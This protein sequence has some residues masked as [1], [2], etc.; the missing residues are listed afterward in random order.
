[1]APGT[2]NLGCMGW[3]NATS[4]S[5]HFAGTVYDSGVSHAAVS[6][7]NGD[8]VLLDEGFALGINN[9]GQAVGY[10][11]GPAL[12]DAAGNL[13]HLL[14][15]PGDYFSQ[16]N[17]INNS[18]QIVGECWMGTAN[19]M[20]W[21]GAAAEPVNLGAGHG[22]AINDGGSVAGF[23]EDSN[24]IH[25]AF[26]WTASG[27]LNPLAGGL[28]SEANAINNLG[29]AAGM[30]CDANGGWAC[31]WDANGTSRRLANLN[32]S[33]SSTAWAINSSGAVVGSCDT[34]DASYAVLWQADGSLV[35]LGLLPD[36]TSSIAYGLS[37]SGDIA[38]CSVDAGG[39]PH[40]V[41][42]SIVPEPGS[43]LALLAGLVGLLPRLRRR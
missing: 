33:L 8:V 23:A 4:G 21:N 9:A 7:S 15:P 29:Q 13:T 40:A 17:A 35:N 18:G 5:A 20:L 3:V 42:W 39:M 38:G 26:V 24:G 31:V 10:S 14:L 2:A 22:N 1:M 32:G 37:D 19:V 25:H 36:H 6:D 34:A 27:G 41:V 11:G 43:I 28:A 12:W 16:A 30:I